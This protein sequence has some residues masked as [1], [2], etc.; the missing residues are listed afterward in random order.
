MRPCKRARAIIP[1]AQT[2]L[3]ALVSGGAAF[4]FGRLMQSSNYLARQIVNRAKIPV[5]KTLISG[6]IADLKANS[7]TTAKVNEQGRTMAE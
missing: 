7:T 3:T 4:P 5:G 2:A 6:M 1:G